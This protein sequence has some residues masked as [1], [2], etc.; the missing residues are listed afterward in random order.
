MSES[1]DHAYPYLNAFIGGWF[2][3]DY[4]LDGETL[5]EIVASFRRS[6][7]ERDWQAVRTDIEGFLKDRDDQQVA[8]D[9]SK[10]FQTDV[11]PAEWGMTPRAWL[12]TLSSLL[13]AS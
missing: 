12:E 13:S 11:G 6:S 7:P 5:E 1:Q 2:H 3:Q 4:D 8:A 9:F 10:L